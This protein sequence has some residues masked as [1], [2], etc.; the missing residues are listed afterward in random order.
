L[1]QNITDADY[2]GKPDKVIVPIPEPMP[3]AVDDPEG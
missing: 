2:D 3:Q 1:F